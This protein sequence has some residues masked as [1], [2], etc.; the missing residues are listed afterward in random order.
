KPGSLVMSAVA[1]PNTDATGVA[2]ASGT[3]PVTIVSGQTANLS[4]TMASAIDHLEVSPANATVPVGSPLQ[5]SATAKHTSN[6]VVL[7]T[8]S[9]LQWSSS[10]PGTIGIDQTGKVTATSAGPSQITVTD[11]ESG[12]AV[13]TTITGQSAAQQVIYI[14]DFH[15][16][17]IKLFDASTGAY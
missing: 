13:S 6:N 15:A 3:T 14:D 7:I 16:G 2:Q 9:K 11:T 10:N 17:A 5:L 1:Y 8:S 12:K 4:L